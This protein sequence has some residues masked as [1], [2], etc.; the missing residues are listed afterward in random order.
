M[1]SG[2]IK[3]GYDGLIKARKFRMHI[4]STAN[5]GF[6]IAQN[7]VVRLMKLPASAVISNIEMKWEAGGGTNTLTVRYGKVSDD[8]STHVDLKTSLVGGSAGYWRMV[9]ETAAATTTLVAPGYE[10]YLELEM[11]GTNG[12]P[13]DKYIEGMVYYF[14]P[15][16]DDEIT[17]ADDI[18]ATS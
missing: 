13:V 15:T 1:K 12:W 3:D 17:D 8:S 6:A 4:A 7:D 5:G 2:A 10:F 9:D 14:T 11:A 18:M 16:F